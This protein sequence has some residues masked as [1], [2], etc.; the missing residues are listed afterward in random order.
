MGIT[1]K[2][3]STN[4]EGWDGATSSSDETSVMGVERRGCILKRESKKKKLGNHKRYGV[5]EAG[6]NLAQPKPFWEITKGM[7]WQAY[8]TV[9][10]NGGAGGVD[11]KSIED[12]ESDLEN[13]LYKIWN[14]LASGSYFPPPVLAVA[15]PKKNG[16]ERI[17][18]IPTVG[19]RIAQMVVKQFI[20]PKIDPIFHPDSY[21][22]RPNKSAHDALGAVRKRCWMYDWVLEFD[23]K[24]LF[25]NIDHGLLQK[26]VEWNVKDKWVLLYIERWLKASMVRDGKETSREKGTPQGGVVS[27]ILSN[28]FLHYAFDLWMTRK[29]PGSPFARYADDAVI[30]CRTKG[31]AVEVK[32][33]L[34]ERL[35]EVGLELHPDKTKIVYCK[36]S[37]R[38]GGEHEEIQFDFLGYT[39][40]P[41][42]AMN[43][44]GKLFTSFTPAVSRKAKKA[45][46]ETIRKWGVRLR[47]D[48]TLQEIA[49]FCDPKV[50]GW[51]NYYGRYHKSALYAVLRLLNG[52]L[53]NWARRTL[54]SLKGSYR[55]AYK[56]PKGFA[57][58]HPTL[59]V[60]WRMLPP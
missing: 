41:R 60:H 37:N 33:Q 24:G 36:D 59:F 25:D 51:I 47:S 16:G 39:F 1:H 19:D 18:G 58:A 35:A 7:V 15:I 32:R 38:P 53:I 57:K 23:I 54:K 5:Q 40:K 13:N 43:K 29:H 44:L 45:I 42:M 21:G 26:A 46:N 48:K 30:H 4:A 2:N 6:M 50:R 52:A 14:R 22:Y 31:E 8:K 56:W 11:G 12:F 34:E 49:V 20:E 55:K 17:L 27:P 3:Q 10:A 28:L 9:K